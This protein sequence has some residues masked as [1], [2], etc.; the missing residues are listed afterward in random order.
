MQ[1]VP[2]AVEGASNLRRLLVNGE[3]HEVASSSLSAL[4]EE[5]GYGGQKVAT[6]VNGEFV[7]E[8]RRLE[9]WLSPGDE[10]EIV[11]PRQGG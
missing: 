11:A 4:L 8:R 6:A 9:T 10:I 1:G 5:L 3:P 2:A 7:A